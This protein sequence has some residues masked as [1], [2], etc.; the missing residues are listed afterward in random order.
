M[1]IFDKT[2]KKVGRII[3]D[4]KKMFDAVIEQKIPPYLDCDNEKELID[5]YGGGCITKRQLE[6]GKEYFANM[7][8]N[9]SNNGKVY[10][11]IISI[12]SDCVIALRGCQ[13]DL[14]NEKR[15]EKENRL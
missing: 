3:A 15:N 7:T 14:R 6:E 5:A 12:L 2:I 1:D 13:Y 11:L 4:N 10:R 9:L 8:E